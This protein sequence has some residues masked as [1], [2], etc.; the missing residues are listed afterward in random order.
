MNI[1]NPLISIVSP[2]YRAEGIVEELVLRLTQSLSSITDNFEIILV[3]DASPDKSWCE[4]L[5]AT[6]KDSRVKGVNLSRNFGQHY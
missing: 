6:K 2:V 5:E 4:I 3:N 1:G